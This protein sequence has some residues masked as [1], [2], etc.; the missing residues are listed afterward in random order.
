[1]YLGVVDFLK[2]LHASEIVENILDND[3]ML[4]KFSSY[5]WLYIIYFHFMLLIIIY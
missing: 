5:E 4:D 1:M 3:N 2:N